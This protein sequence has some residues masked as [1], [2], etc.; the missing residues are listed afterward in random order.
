MVVH[1]AC[2][3]VSRLVVPGELQTLEMLVGEACWS[4]LLVTLAKFCV[5]WV[6]RLIGLF[7]SVFGEPCW[8]NL[9]SDTCT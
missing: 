8:M 9:V 3:F 7:L 6:T 2:W 1:E 4:S 5:M